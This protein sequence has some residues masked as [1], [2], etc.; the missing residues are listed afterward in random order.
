MWDFHEAPSFFSGKGEANVC[1][2]INE[3]KDFFMSANN[4]VSGFL[5]E[6]EGNVKLDV[7]KVKLEFFMK[8]D[9]YLTLIRN[10]SSL[11]P[12]RALKATEE[13]K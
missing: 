2:K 3:T 11:N 4:L 10:S 6:S 9:E 8:A 1:V 5:T 13:R 12:L 7:E